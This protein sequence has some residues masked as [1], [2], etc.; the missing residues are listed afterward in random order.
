MRNPNACYVAVHC[1]REGA[2]LLGSVAERGGPEGDRFGRLVS[3]VGS[4]YWYCQ[5]AHS[6]GMDRPATQKYTSM[7]LAKLTLSER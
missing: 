5:L 7:S 2:T 6:G 4:I 1:S 3:T